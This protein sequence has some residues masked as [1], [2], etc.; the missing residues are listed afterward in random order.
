MSV[1]FSLARFFSPFD[2][3]R[4]RRAFQKN[5]WLPAERLRAMQEER[6]Q[7]MIAH[8]YQRVP[9]YRRVMS[10]AG[11]R[12]DDIR[13]VEDLKRLP[14]LARADIR[15]RPDDFKSDDFARHY[16]TAFHTSGSSGQRLDF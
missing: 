14:V 9:H 15:S 3:L 4:F 13:R 16:P 10:E 7:E 2:I 5:Q 8:A 6:L 11:L 12:P 1:E